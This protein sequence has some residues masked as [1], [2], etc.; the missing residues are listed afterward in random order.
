MRMPLPEAGPRSDR[1]R[2]GGRES[3]FLAVKA[4]PMNRFLIP[5][6]LAC[7]ALTAAAADEAGDF[8][9]AY[10]ERIHPLLVTTCGKCHSKTPKGNDLDLT[11]L[12]TAEAILA[13][14]KVL[15]DVAERLSE[16]DMP[17]QKAPQ[18]SQAEREQLLAW[19]SAAVD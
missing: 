1:P 5:T 10:A 11:S 18:P 19:I 8:S 6:L 14:P 16:G 2:C 3:K 15:V 9:R 13:Q 7:L 12:G 4:R 17:P